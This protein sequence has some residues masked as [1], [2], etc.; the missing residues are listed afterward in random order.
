MCN[1]GPGYYLFA[2]ISVHSPPLLWVAPHCQLNCENV[3]GTILLFGTLCILFSS[4][5][6]SLSLSSA[7]LLFQFIS[8]SLY[9]R[10]VLSL[11]LQS[12]AKMGGEID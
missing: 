8:S 5:F 11:V 10:S 4:L 7:A 3:C 2:A 9:Y 6:L 12:H 1:K